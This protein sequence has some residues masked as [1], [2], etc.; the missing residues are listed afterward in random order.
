ML[1]TIGLIYAAVYPGF[2]SRLSKLGLTA[3]E[4][5]LCCMYVAGYSSKEIEDI[6]YANKLYQQNTIIRKKLGLSPNG[7]KLS[8][9]LR[10]LF[11]ELNGRD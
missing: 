1:A 7:E 8:S 3:E 6:K 2:V 9:W 5:G 10:V 11:E 4:I